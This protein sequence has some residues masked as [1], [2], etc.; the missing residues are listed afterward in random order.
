MPS[1]RYLAFALLSTLSAYATHSAYA[2]DFTPIE[3][4]NPGL[5]VDLGVGLWSWP[6]P[7]DLDGDGDNDLVVSCPDKP[8]N[9][10]YFFENTEGDVKF[11]VFQPGVKIGPAL[12][13]VQSS[14]VDGKPRLLLPGKEQVGLSLA[15]LG[16]AKKLPLDERLGYEGKMRA[17]QWKYADYDADGLLDLIIGQG[18]WTD[19]GWDDAFD[20]LGNWTRGPLHGY[21]YFARNTGTN[22][23]PDYAEPV[24]ITA[25]GKPVDVYGMPSPNLGDFDGD[26]DLDLICGEFLD[27]FTW[28]ENV[29][30]RTKPEYSAGQRLSSD[31]KPIL[32]NLQMIVP[33]AFDWDKDGDLDL[34]CGDEDGRVAFIEHTGKVVDGMPQFNQPVYFQQ[35]AD[36]V[37]CGALVTPVSFDWDGDGD[38]DLVCGNTAGYIEF[39][40]NLGGKPTKW[41]AAKRLTA[42]GKTIRFQAGP[43]G[44]IQGPCEAKWGYTTQTIGDWDHDGLPDLVVNSIW[45]KVVWL[46]NIGTRTNPK[47][48][49]EQPLEVEW[50]GKAPKPDWFWWNPKGKNLV[51]QW[52]TTPVVVDFNNDQLNDLVML[53]HE[54]YL[55]FFQRTKSDDGELHLQPGQRI[56]TRRIRRSH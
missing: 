10:V 55:A 40:E 49:T 11:P 19:Y 8:M 9:G 37:K 44:S 12:K 42:D 23:K 14:Y 6:M 16:E 35:Q 13:N 50:P 4:N 20:A 45:G 1:V 52:R 43:N 47:L 15:S 17:N 22:E 29:G 36:K 34:I 18:I 53:D 33:T 32:M 31:G 27:G 24:K 28:F 7:M 46:R 48:A 38:D 25:G 41:A 3:Y 2:E 56:F 39:F 54:G 21:V 5:K 26:G 51:T 30:S